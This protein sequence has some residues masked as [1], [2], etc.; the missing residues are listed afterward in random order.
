MPTTAS[1]VSMS[2]FDACNGSPPR[3]T[4]FAVH[5]F[6]FRLLACLFPLFPRFLLDLRCLREACIADAEQFGTAAVAATDIVRRHRRQD[7]S[8]SVLG[9]SRSSDKALGKALLGW[10]H[11]PCK[12][13][14]DRYP[15]VHRV[16]L[17]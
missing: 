10:G 8:V 3:V 1:S 5:L 13:F 9:Q 12:V 11:G 17:A 4:E 14:G 6:A 7:E 16:K 15:P 2:C